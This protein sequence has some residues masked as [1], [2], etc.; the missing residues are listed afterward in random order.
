MERSIIVTEDGSHSMYVPL[1]NEHYHSTHGA[2]QESMYVFIQ[3]GLMQVEAD[4]VT[5]F[6]VGF[7]T[8][9]NALLTYLNLP[10]GKRVTYISVEKYPLETDEVDHLNYAQILNPAAQQAFRNMH[11]CE[12]GSEVLISDNFTLLKVK[13][14]LSD[15]QYNSLPK[16]DLIYFDA[17][18]PEKQPKMWNPQ[19]FQQLRMQCNNGAIFVT[20][21]AKGQVRRDLQQAGFLMERLP[22]PPGKFQMLRGKVTNP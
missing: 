7:G 17:F 8:G 11:D 3:A 4:H 18:A 19:L 14:D 6:E 9:L 5:I 22:G 1:L 2:I 15:I 16:F 13:G 12:W 20:Y 10:A 21:C